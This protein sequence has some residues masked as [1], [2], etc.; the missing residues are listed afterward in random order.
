MAVYDLALEVKRLNDEN[1]R[2][3]K[4]ARSERDK[5]IEALIR[6]TTPTA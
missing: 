1:K 3:R 6:K 2:L 5:S 4:E